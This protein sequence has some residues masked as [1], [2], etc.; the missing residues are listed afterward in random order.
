[1]SDI[2]HGDYAPN[3]R[4]KE[5]HE[6]RLGLFF[7]GT[8]NNKNNIEARLEN[9][10][11]FRRYNRSTSYHNDFSNVARLWLFYEKEKDIYVEGIGTEDDKPDDG[12]SGSGLGTGPTGVPAK[13]RIGCERVVEK[14]ADFSKI[15]FLALD[16]FGFSRGAAAARH[17]VHEIS[18]EPNKAKNIPPWGYLGKL[19]VDKGIEVEFL[20][21]RFLGLFDTVS[22]YS[23]E[24]DAT[25]DFSNDVE[26]LQLNDIGKAFK[27]VQF[28][29]ANEH[30]KNF[31]L[32]RIPKQLPTHIDIEKELPGEH[33]DIGGSHNDGVETV[34][35]IET[36]WGWKKTDKL[37]RLKNQLVEEGWYTEGNLSIDEGI[38][39]SSLN[40]SR[41]VL[42]TYS[43]IPLHFMAELGINKQE[44]LFDLEGLKSQFSIKGEPLLE[45]VEKRLRKYVFTAELGPY[46]YIP[47]SKEPEQQDLKNLRHIYLH[48]SSNYE[49]VV[50]VNA[51]AK[52]RK[53][54]EY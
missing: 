36:Q 21:I 6:L 7:D 13:M 16:V 40:G 1:M 28:T 8:K 49:G 18:K 46:R 17:F 45:R 29:A 33:C 3:D 39:Y 19:L 30:R 37:E 53:R 54:I 41:Y 11:S 32:T 23:A 26:E 44:V 38:T 50:G 35:E 10:D 22:A 12:I 9:K 20:E 48:W 25:P 4:K 15:R 52:N 31:A 5:K 27:I 42:K 43:Y 14:A 34:N 47:N 51:P 2:I 24:F